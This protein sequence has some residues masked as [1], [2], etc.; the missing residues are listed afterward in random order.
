MAEQVDCG[1]GSVF[2]IEVSGCDGLGL[3]LGLWLKL[4]LGLGLGLSESNSTY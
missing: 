4:E 1:G 3:G 2:N